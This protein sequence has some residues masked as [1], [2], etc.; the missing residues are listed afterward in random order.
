MEPKKVIDKIINYIGKHGVVAGGAVR[1]VVLGRVP[2]DYDVFIF[3]M[4]DFMGIIKKK[5]IFDKKPQKTERPF[6]S[7]YPVMFEV[8]NTTL[9]KHPVQIIWNPRYTS[10]GSTSWWGR[11]FDLRQAVTGEEVVSGF[12]FTINMMY[13]DHNKTYHITDEAET[14]LRKRLIIFNKR[15]S[16][17]LAGPMAS[18]NHLFRRMVYLADKLG[19]IIDSKAV[20]NIYQ[21]YEPSDIE[22]E[23]LQLK[24]LKTDDI[25]F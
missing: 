4:D 9:S 7:R 8:Y 23:A 6:A 18:V 11:H 2:K 10:E 12:D 20:K 17:A 25:L 5:G 21:K 19:F 13:V 15:H 3:G 14:A 24:E 22:M 16:P 1:D